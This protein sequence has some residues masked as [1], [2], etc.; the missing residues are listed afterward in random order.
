MRVVQGG[1]S[2]C[3]HWDRSIQ[4]RNSEPR[5]FGSVRR[6]RGTAVS[7]SPRAA[8]KRTTRRPSAT[9]S[10]P[11]SRTTIATARTISTTGAARRTT[12]TPTEALSSRQGQSPKVTR[13]ELAAVAGV[14]A[15]IALRALGGSS[16]T[17]ATA[18]TTTT[19]SSPLL[20]TNAPHPHGWSGR[21]SIPC[22]RGRG[23]G[24]E[25]IRALDQGCAR[26]ES[27]TAEQQLSIQYFI[28][29]HSP[30]SSR[31]A[32]TCSRSSSCS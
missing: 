1:T 10:L 24:N 8:P 5:R 14:L 20:R 13:A 21:R 27:R 6:Y 15:Y 29:V 2:T 30:S 11:L 3:T 19:N 25:H 18:I 7:S 9:T 17:I 12:D 32:G 4:Y 22:A 28:H 26:A 31:R 16:S 23:A